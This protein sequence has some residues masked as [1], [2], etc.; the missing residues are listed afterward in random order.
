MKVTV[1]MGVNCQYVCLPAQGVQGLGQWNLRLRYVPCPFSNDDIMY[2]TRHGQARRYACPQ[3]SHLTSE[4]ID[5]LSR[6]S[7]TVRHPVRQG[8]SAREQCIKSFP[9]GHFLQGTSFN[10]TF[11]L[12]C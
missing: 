10:I 7:P 11:E 4:V 2:V 1:V 12:W 9:A 8:K 5:R 6:A 3:H